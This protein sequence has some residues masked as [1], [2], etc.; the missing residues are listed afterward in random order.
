MASKDD[1]SLLIRFFTLREKNEARSTTEGRD[2]F[3]EIE[4]ISIRVLGSRDELVT[5]VTDDY[6]LRFP[7]EYK[8]FKRDQAAPLT[9]TP[10]EEW[11]AAASSFID[12]MR[13]YGIRTVDQLAA[14]SD[15]I[16]MINPG[17]MTMRTRAQA[18]LDNAKHNAMSESLAVENATLKQ[19]MAAMQAQM[20]Q[21]MAMVPTPVQTADTPPATVADAPELETADAG[22]KKR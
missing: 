15:G 8:A 19:Q 4:C 14:L 3:D 9:G 22:T 10:L 17:W 6:R 2:I 11:P 5:A 18:F 12:E 21:L 1:A 20:Q 7:D 13:V 16:A